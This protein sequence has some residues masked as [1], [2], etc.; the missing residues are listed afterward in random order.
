MLG[1]PHTRA[2]RSRPALHRVGFGASLNSPFG[3]ETLSDAIV[4]V[5]HEPKQLRAGLYKSHTFFHFIYILKY[6]FIHSFH[7][8][9][10]ETEFCTQF[11]FDS[12]HRKCFLL[13]E[14]HFILG[15]KLSLFSKHHCGGNTCLK[16]IVSNIRLDMQTGS[17]LIF[18]QACLL[19]LHI[20]LK[21]L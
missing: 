5:R 11:G 7:T 9:E 17:F 19:H 16:E 15:D 6:S 3:I 2:H 20:L 21:V 18:L 13:L 8:F 10:R 1:S 4:Y 14:D 12:Q